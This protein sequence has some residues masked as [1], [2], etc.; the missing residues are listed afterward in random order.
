MLRSSTHLRVII[1]FV[2]TL[3]RQAVAARIAQAIAAINYDKVKPSVSADRQDTYTWGIIIIDFRSL[4]TSLR[5]FS[6]ASVANI[7]AVAKV[8]HLAARQDEVFRH[9][10][11]NEC[12]GAVSGYDRSAVDGR[13]DSKF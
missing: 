12:S 3:P 13:P 1:T 4:F 5:M 6:T 8:E 10:G 9:V 2:T 11:W 7:A